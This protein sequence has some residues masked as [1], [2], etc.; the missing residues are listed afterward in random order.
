MKIM[1]DTIDDVSRGIRAQ[2]HF[3]CQSRVHNKTFGSIRSDDA[4]WPENVPIIEWNELRREMAYAHEEP[5]VKGFW[6][7]FYRFRYIVSQIHPKRH[8]DHFDEENGYT[9]NFSERIYEAEKTYK[10]AVRFS[11]VFMVCIMA[12]IFTVLNS[13]EEND[14]YH[15]SVSVFPLLQSFLCL[16]IHSQQAKMC[17]LI[18]EKYD[19]ADDNENQKE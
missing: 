7:S 9:I 14:M 17:R 11:I 3:Y 16:M 8:L 5:R 10:S 15:V 19:T 1:T 18:L 12:I 13:L 4:T 6:N 2:L